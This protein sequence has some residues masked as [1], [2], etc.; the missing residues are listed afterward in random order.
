[1]HDASSLFVLLLERIGRQK[2]GIFTIIAVLCLDL[3][4]I[5]VEIAKTNI[6]RNK[7]YHQFDINKKKY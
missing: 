5:Y 4:E 2:S 7:H 1:M 6:V 3:T